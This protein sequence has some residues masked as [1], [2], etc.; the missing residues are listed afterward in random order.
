ME[1]L[2]SAEFQETLL[3]GKFVYDSSLPQAANTLLQSFASS[4]P[5]APIPL[6][7]TWK[8]FCSFIENSKESTSCSPSQRHYGH[9]KSLLHSA[10]TIL[11][12]IFKIMCLALKPG[13]VLDRWK[14][15]VTTLLCKEHNSPKIHRLRPIHI[16]EAELQFFLNITGPNASLNK[17]NPK[18][19]FLSHN[20]EAE[21]T[22]R[23]K[24]RSS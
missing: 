7:P 19:I 5:S 12:G 21:K 9:Y 2:N 10:P 24:V 15:T 20:M 4:E 3:N 16:I 1:K 18:D 22:N 23:L 11:K 8:E 17:L 13:I 14:T 6:L